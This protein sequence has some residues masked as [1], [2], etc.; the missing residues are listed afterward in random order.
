MVFERERARFRIGLFISKDR[1]TGPICDRREG[2]RKEKPILN[3]NTTLGGSLSFFLSLP[4]C[5]LPR[6][7]LSS[8][9]R[10]SDRQRERKKLDV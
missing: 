9:I 1:A 10:V 8:P 6:Q 2:E 7:F 3:K 5:S 4:F